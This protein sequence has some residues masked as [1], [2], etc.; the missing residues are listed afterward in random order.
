MLKEMDS[1]FKADKLKQRWKIKPVFHGKLSQVIQCVITNTGIFKYGHLLK[2]YGKQSP[3]EK[4]K[5]IRQ[6]EK[7]KMHIE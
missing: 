4:S 5:Q 3:L 6:K 7:P 1:A 2:N